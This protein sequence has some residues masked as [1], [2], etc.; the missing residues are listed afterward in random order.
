MKEPP[1]F[2][3]VADRK[4]RRGRRGSFCA[5]L[6]CKNKLNILSCIS[7]SLLL[8]CILKGKTHRESS[9]CEN[10]GR[11]PLPSLSFE[12]FS[13][14]KWEERILS[15]QN[16]RALSFTPPKDFCIENLSL[17]P[18]S[19]FGSSPLRQKK[20]SSS[21]LEGQPLHIKADI[22]SNPRV[23]AEERI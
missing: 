11:D 3:H 4:R 15:K 21:P 22:T 14:R 5:L 13:W 2:S 18:T 12:I 17:S 6:I 9:L 19:L 7:F 16:I 10:I 8:L 20:S 1:S 23:A